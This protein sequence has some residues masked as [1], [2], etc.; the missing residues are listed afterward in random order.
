[1]LHLFLLNEPIC[2]DTHEL[3]ILRMIKDTK[4]KAAQNILQRCVLSVLIL[5]VYFLIREYYG[6]I[7]VTRRLQ[8]R[9]WCTQAAQNVPA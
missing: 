4:I 1:M 7:Y 3:N 5:T 6:N 9:L 8:W 2:S